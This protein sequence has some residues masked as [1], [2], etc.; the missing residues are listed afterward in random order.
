MLYCTRIHV[1]LPA[2]MDT[3]TVNALRQREKDRAVELQQQ[4]KLVHLWR[5]AG[6][7]ANVSVWNCA[8]HDEFHDLLGSLPM[9]PFFE[10]EVIPLARH[11]SAIA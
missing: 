6:Q 10:I 4:G 7:T 1:R 2:T 3:E 11:P 8:S 5:V 9:F